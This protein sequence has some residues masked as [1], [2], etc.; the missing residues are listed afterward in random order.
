MHVSL[1]CWRYVF[2]HKYSQ[3]CKRVKEDGILRA[4]ARHL[5]LDDDL[6]AYTCY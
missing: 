6:Y 3:S 4:V 2:L 1:N 5:D